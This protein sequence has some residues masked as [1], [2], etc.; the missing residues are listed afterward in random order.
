[1]HLD[2]TPEINSTD[3]SQ[4]FPLIQEVE[5][6]TSRTAEKANALNTTLDEFSMLN[7]QC[8]ISIEKIRSE[9]VTVKTTHTTSYH[10]K[11]AQTNYR[12]EFQ[13]TPERLYF[14]HATQTPNHRQLLLSLLAGNF[15]PIPSFT[16]GE[17]HE[18]QV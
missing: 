3:K 18:F 10:P 11:S 6:V 14:P 8:R 5:M 2:F 7:K 9:T 4:N 17:P 13:Y 12:V 1:M 16:S 15:P